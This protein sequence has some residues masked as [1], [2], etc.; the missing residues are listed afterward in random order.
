MRTAIAIVLLL[1]LSGSSSCQRSE[2]GA[3]RVATRTSEADDHPTRVALSEPA[4]EPTASAV[5]SL[6]PPRLDPTLR[7]A[8][9]RFDVDTE[10]LRR[11][12]PWIPDAPRLEALLPEA[13]A[14]ALLEKWAVE[15]TFARIEREH[16]VSH[17]VHGIFTP[18][19]PAA[20]LEGIRAQVGGWRLDDREDIAPVL[21]LLDPGLA[22]G[23]VV[24]SETPAGPAVSRWATD[25]ET[26]TPVHLYA[27][28]VPGS[29]ALQ[30][31]LASLHPIHNR[32]ETLDTFV[33]SLPGH[34][35]ARGLDRINDPLHRASYRREL[36]SSPLVEI[37]FEQPTDP[38]LERA[39]E[40][41]PG[42]SLEAHAKRYDPIAE[43]AHRRWAARIDRWAR[44]RG[45]SPDR[46]DERFDTVWISRK[47][48]AYLML[49][50][51]CTLWIGRSWDGRDR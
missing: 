5:A 25:P 17:R 2:S 31:S 51:T 38:E 10:E 33:A 46:S 28:M 45:F 23:R 26:G 37:A 39:L 42:E 44:G 20:T 13:P 16:W 14:L 18:E 40:R 49:E 12:A 3:E 32:D 11:P 27:G 43:R 29:A 6:P 36:G 8:A 4:Q 47:P 50:S 7:F 41:R 22:A 35:L 48:P 24:V 19:D 21:T 15:E 30:I 1:L 9:S 34:D